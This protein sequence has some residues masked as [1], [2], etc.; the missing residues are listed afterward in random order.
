MHAQDAPTLCVD[1]VLRVFGNAK[2]RKM[3]FAVPFQAYADQSAALLERRQ[4]ASL[5]E[6]P[7]AV[8]ERCC[9]ELVCTSACTS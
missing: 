4:A 3:K 6:Y 2:R 1:P 7:D 8:F 9:L 5:R